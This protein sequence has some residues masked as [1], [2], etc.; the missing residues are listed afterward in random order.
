MARAC[1]DASTAEGCRPS[2]VPHKQHVCVHVPDGGEAVERGAVH[3]SRDQACYYYYDEKSGVIFGWVFFL[4]SPAHLHV[5][6]PH[7]AYVQASG[8]N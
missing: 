4:T 7:G 6:P 8:R 1:A 5:H 3:P 2:V